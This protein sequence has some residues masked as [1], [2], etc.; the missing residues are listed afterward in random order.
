MKKTINKFVYLVLC[1]IIVSSCN[2]DQY[3]IDPNRPTVVEP[4]ALL[5]NILF[6][7]FKN[8][9][10]WE[11]GLVMRHDIA[12][13]DRQAYQTYEWSTGSWDEYNILRDVQKMIDAPTATEEHVAI[14]HILRAYHFF[15]LTRMYGDVPYTHALA[16]EHDTHAIFH[17]IYDSQ[18]DI[19]IGILNELDKANTLLTDHQ[20]SI[21]GDII[22]QGNMSKWRKLA[23]SFSLKILMSLSNH[24]T[25]S[26]I[27]VVERFKNIMQNPSRFP[28]FENS[29]DEV[30]L[31]YRDYEFIRYPLYQDYNVQNK[32]FMGK[33]L[34]DLMKKLEDPRLFY[35][36]L[37]SQQSIEDGLDKYNFNAYN[38][39]DGSLSLTDVT[40]L[41]STGLYSRIHVTNYTTLPT[42]KPSL[43]YSYAE[44]ML[45]LE[46]AQQ[47]GWIANNKDYY[48]K[49]IQASFSY[50]NLPD[51]VQNYLNKNPLV[52]HKEQALQQ[53]YEQR[54][55]LFFHQ[56]DFEV[57]FDYHRTGYP[58]I[59]VGS[60]QATDAVPFRMMYPLS[61]RNTNTDNYAQAL[62][63]QGI[64]KESIMNPLWIHKIK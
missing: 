47:R 16:G 53:L 42:G 19:L 23:N 40:Q 59:K 35:F 30:Q 44:L 14:G 6:Q 52:D 5:P 51:A 8:R 57:L 18:K 7:S 62:Q 58:I 49:A 33:P 3:N 48:E 17:P 50:Y 22:Y 15:F 43:A 41:A 32:R 12:I 34:I 37:P 9:Y 27:K 20:K 39:I 60:G 26:E 28:I 25:D 4:Q 31:S 61:E 63:R 2:V 13:S 64:A 24:T 11:P 36:A 55:I 1:S 29:Q 45:I 38:G 54:Y 21:E 10:P 56:C 46:E